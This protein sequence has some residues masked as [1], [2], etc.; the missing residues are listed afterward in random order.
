M[1]GVLT[2]ILTDQGSN[3]TSQLLKEVYRKN[4]AD[5]N[6]SIPSPNRWFGGT[7]Q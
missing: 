5:A 4:R 1:N 2:E 7:F 6:K 3:F